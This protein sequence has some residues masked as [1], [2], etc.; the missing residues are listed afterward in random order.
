MYSSTLVTVWCLC[1]DERPIVDHEDYPRGAERNRYFV[2]VIRERLRYAEY[3]VED[4][5]LGNGG[6]SADLPIDPVYYAERLGHQ[7]IP[8]AKRSDSTVPRRLR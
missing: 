5:H 7:E 3:N 8:A 2:R 6:R 1:L 4:L